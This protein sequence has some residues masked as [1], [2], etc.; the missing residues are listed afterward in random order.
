MS[1]M[2]Q[3]P[4]I[5][6]LPESEWDETLAGAVSA[7]GR[8]LNV[9]TTLGRH[10]ELFR[11][12]IGLGTMLLMKGTLS[13][14]DRELAILRSAHNGNCTYEWT[15]HVTVARDAGLDDDEIEALRLGLD[16]YAWAPADRAVVAAADELHFAGTLG[17]EAWSALASRLDETQMIELVVLIGHYQ[18]LAYALNSMNVQ[19]EAP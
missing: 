1:A 6:P 14:R 2:S 11:A 18:M 4:R 5:D 17:E 7:L 10:R 13:G 8:P 9:L 19:L 16:E 3:E 12:W 15:H